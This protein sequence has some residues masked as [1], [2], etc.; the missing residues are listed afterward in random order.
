M[1]KLLVSILLTMVVGVGAFAK[2][3]V[4]L[5][6]PESIDFYTKNAATENVSIKTYF[7]VSLTQNNF[8]KSEWKNFTHIVVYDK[9]GC[10]YSIWVC[11]DNSLCRF[12]I[13][14]D[15]FTG[16][17]IGSYH[18]DT[19]KK[20]DPVQIGLNFIDKKILK[21]IDVEKYQTVYSWFVPKENDEQS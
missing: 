11:T 1:K 20:A 9:S 21:I 18:C 10:I 15:A 4:V 6:D 17:L 12:G 19:V 7:E 14:V 2:S 16:Q 5:T 3:F 13:T 8:P